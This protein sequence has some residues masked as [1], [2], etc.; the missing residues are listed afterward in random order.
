MK[1]V[2][3]DKALA[4]YCE[5]KVLEPPKMADTKESELP[6]TWQYDAPPLLKLMLLLHLNIDVLQVILLKLKPYLFPQFAIS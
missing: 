2:A 3:A 1:V 4:K 6:L 5:I